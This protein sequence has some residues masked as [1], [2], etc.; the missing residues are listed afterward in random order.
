VVLTVLVLTLLGAILTAAPASAHPFGPPPTALVAARGNAVLVD[1]RSAPD[2]AIAIGIH[3]GLLPEETMDAYLEAQTQVAPSAADEEL[4]ARSPELHDYL[5]EHIRVLQDGRPCEPNLQ[6]VGDFVRD[7][8]RIIHDCAEDVEVVEIEI[9]MLH[10][11]HSAY[12]TFAVAENETTV[13]AQAVFTT[14]APRQQMD[15]SGSAGSGG[16][17]GAEGADSEAG[18]TID[19]EGSGSALAVLGGL[20][21]L[22][23][24]IV[25]GRARRRRPQRPV[26]AA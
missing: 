3:V 1:W 23:A 15:F 8:A 12:R 7:G 21:L 20:A 17:D 16:S 2:D 10:D 25:A 22:L 9:T 13:P 6:P 19:A 26:D 14:A 11:I 5:L 24:A 18:T 4:L